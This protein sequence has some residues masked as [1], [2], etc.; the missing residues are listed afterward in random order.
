MFG[1]KLQKICY[2]IASGCYVGY[3]PVM[4]GTWASLTVTGILF[5]MPEIFLTAHLGLIG[6]LF[7]MG[8]VSISQILK[9]TQEYDPSWIVIDE[10]WGM[11]IALM[12]V[13]KVF[14]AYAVA[15]ILFRFFDIIKIAPI[16]RLER[17]PGNWGI[18]LD[19]GLAGIFALLGTHMFC[20]IK[21]TLSF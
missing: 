14:Q 21:T 17:L 6:I 20:L 9:Q 11:S 16:N 5:F 19:D 8:M 15:F 12:G 1:N 7:S 3:L 18:M 10:W 2:A 13:P 4:P